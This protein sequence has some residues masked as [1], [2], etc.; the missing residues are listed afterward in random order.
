MTPYPP[1]MCMA[2][3]DATADALPPASLSAGVLPGALLSP[4]G[5]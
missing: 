1:E 2:I 3:A 4:L 5:P